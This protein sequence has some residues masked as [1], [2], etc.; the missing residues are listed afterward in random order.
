MS[1]E[2]E[3]VRTS[4]GREV[5]VEQTPEDEVLL[6]HL[7][8]DPKT[9]LGA[10]YDRYGALI[11]GVA[12]AVLSSPDEAQ[13]VTQETFL[14]L[15][16]NS[17]RY[18]PARGSLP[19]FLVAMARSR[20]LDRLRAHSRRTELLHRWKDALVPASMTGDPH[21]HTSI[22]QTRT[23][24]RDALAALPDEQGRVLNLAYYQGLTQTEISTHLGVPLGTVKSWM[25]RGLFA[26]RDELRDL[27]RWP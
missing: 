4:I 5:F 8:A 13:D 9:A 3:Q 27:A 14:A 12:R 21:M 18:D 16:N 26:L 24:V 10:I 23:R 20:A 17:R 2:S 1:A 11:Y 15:Y 22:E 19:A 7:A 25:R 6:R